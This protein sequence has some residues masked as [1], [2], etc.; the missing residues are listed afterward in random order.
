MKVLYNDKKVEQIN[1]YLF[2]DRYRPLSCRNSCWP[3]EKKK[4]GLAA[5][6]MLASR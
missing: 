1:D 6:K 3:P 2:I 4:C 5:E